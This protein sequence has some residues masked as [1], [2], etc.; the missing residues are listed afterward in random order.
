MALDPSTVG[1]SSSP[2]VF[3]WDADLAMLYALGVGAGVDDLAYTTDN[4][5]NLEQKVLPTFPVLAVRG[6][7]DPTG[8]LGQIGSFD[9][10]MAVHGDQLVEVH[11]PIPPRGAVT[12]THTVTGIFDKGSGAAIVVESASDSV[13]TGKP[14][15]TTTMTLFVRGAGGFGGDRGPS[16]AKVSQEGDPDITVTEATTDS[17]ALLYRLTGDKNPL[18]SDPAFAKRV[19]FER[20]ILHGLCTYG[21]VGRALVDKVC[22]GDDAKF[23]SM[24]AR[25]SSPV[26]PGDVITTSIW[27]NDDGAAFEASTHDGKTV[28]DRGVFQYR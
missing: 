22:G 16:A 18:H 20:P 8:V 3:E 26:V 12:T 21:F 9:M 23:G 10:G 5:E 7:F 14:L 19:G 4:S 13:E 25:F 24:F 6:A 28:L 15:F 1:V 17:Q 27:L 2:V 11:A